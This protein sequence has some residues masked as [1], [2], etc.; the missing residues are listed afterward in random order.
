VP[1]VAEHK[2]TCWMTPGKNKSAS[3][4]CSAWKGTG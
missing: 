2:K 3:L 4:K 1:A